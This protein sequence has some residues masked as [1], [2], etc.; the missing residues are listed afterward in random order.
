[1][2]KNII[3][4]VLLALSAAGGFAQ[5]GAIGNALP[6]GSRAKME[7]A[8]VNRLNQAGMNASRQSFSARSAVAAEP[9]I[10]VIVRMQPG[11]NPDIL[12]AYGAEVTASAMG[13][14]T[15]K[16]TATQLAKMAADARVK[17]M[18][19]LRKT[20][21]F[22][23]DAHARTGVD[24]IKSADGLVQPYTG[25]GVLALIED[26]GIQPSHPMMKREDGTS[27]VVYFRKPDGSV[28]TTAEEYENLH[29]TANYHGTHTSTILAGSKVT[30]GGVAYEGVAPGVDMACF[31][32]DLNQVNNLMALIG[33]AEK[34]TTQPMVASFSIG[35]HSTAS[36]DNDDDV[37]AMLDTL[38]QKMPVCVSSGNSADE[39][40]CVYHVCADGGEKLLVRADTTYLDEG[41]KPRTGAFYFSTQTEKPLKVTVMLT[42]FGEVLYRM[43][44]LDKCTD[45]EYTYL[46]ALGEDAD[47][48]D[49]L[50][51]DI[52]AEHFGGRL[53][54]ASHINGCGRYVATVSLEDVLFGGWGEYGIVF[55]VEGEGGQ[56]IKASGDV[57]NTR[58]VMASAEIEEGAVTDCLTADSNGAAWA[59]A[60]SVISVGAYNSRLSE[61]DIV[62]YHEVLDSLTTFSTYA[63]L[64][65]GRTVPFITA[66]GQ[67]ILAGYNKYSEDEI[68]S[69]T[70]FIDGSDDM[71]C[72]EAGTSMAAPYVAGTI[73]LWLEA[74]PKLSVDEI[75]EIMASTA[76]K[77]HY[78]T[79]AQSIAWGHGKIDAYNGLKEVLSRT[80]TALRP[81]SAD[82]D[83]LMR[84]TDRQVEVF[85]AGETSL[86]AS[87]YSVG[88]ALVARTAAAGDQLTLDASSLPAGVYALKVQG[89]ATSHSA[90][91]V[92]K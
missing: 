15:V 49:C 33:Y 20:G 39:P 88:G 85:V 10:G 48:E 69:S 23:K 35:S 13:F 63:H 6:A 54:I 77:D 73:A 41:I 55:L 89:A 30:V 74:D 64:L 53:G 38:G 51:S 84:Q 60:K 45:G 12:T 8:L 18:S 65:D 31:E 29:N 32:T 76:I 66:P 50:H 80:A 52:F 43:P 7:L 81:V 75:K 36:L 71:L 72:E 70:V 47:D 67:N 2:Y 56:V 61:K 16:A 37:L 68:S 83:F 91:I 46:S 9:L 90:K 25:K 42:R 62:E 57:F 34:Q 79:N 59:H 87:L 24:R 19:L 26:A 82:K 58:L 27:K 92:I 3:A 21:L 4:S 17:H 78:V 22:L 44:V 11:A 5:T 86:T 14:A 1:M 40:T 28:Y